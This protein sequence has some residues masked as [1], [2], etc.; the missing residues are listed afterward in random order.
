ML[1]T[2]E[3]GIA[4]RGEGAKWCY[5]CDRGGGVK[6]EEEKEPW[7]EGRGPDEL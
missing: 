1:A 6:G 5:L 2:V 4:T 7:G 3:P